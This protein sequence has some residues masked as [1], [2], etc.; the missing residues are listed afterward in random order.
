MLSAT[1]GLRLAT[2]RAEMRGKIKSLHS[3]DP[4][5]SG[6]VVVQ[7][8]ITAWGMSY[9][10]QVWVPLERDDYDR[11]LRTNDQGLEVR[12]AGTM[13]RTGHPPKLRPTELF[14]VTST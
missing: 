9:R 8:T 3:E 10:R 12:V 7:E 6:E 2:A 13:T 5:E 1:S 4:N 11:A 14:R